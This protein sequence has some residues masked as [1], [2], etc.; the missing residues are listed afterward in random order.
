M[1]DIAYALLKHGVL[2]AINEEPRTCGAL[3]RDLALHED[4]LCRYATAGVAIGMLQRNEDKFSLTNVGRAY[5]V[6]VR[7]FI[8]LTN[9]MSTEVNRAAAKDSMKT[10]ISGFRNYYGGEL[11]GYEALM[12]DE[13]RKTFNLQDEFEI[14]NRAMVSLGEQSAA[15]VLADYYLTKP[16]AEL[17][18]IGGGEGQL[19]AEFARHWPKT[20]VTVFDL[21]D[22]IENFTNPYLADRLPRDRF[23]TLSGSFFH[24]LPEA[25]GSC[26]IFFLRH[27]LHDWN[28]AQCVKILTHLS[29]IAKPGAKL[30]IIEYIPDPRHDTLEQAAA[31]SFMDINMIALSPTGAKQRSPEHFSRLLNLALHN[32]TSTSSWTLLPTRSLHSVLEIPL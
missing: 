16:R 19:V 13:L 7:D 31:K 20:S 30:V 6:Q 26:D 4:Y 29:K 2:D 22:V 8:E 3:A 27:I 9:S 15:A 10:G 17:C 28:D 21:P 25:L 23:K 14:A 11:D 12:T 5:T 32:S 24:K 1:S 18:D